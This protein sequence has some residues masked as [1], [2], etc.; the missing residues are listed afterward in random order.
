LTECVVVGNGP[1]S[2]L[3][4]GTVDYA[5]NV[6]GGRYKPQYLYAVDPWA[7]FDIVKS[8]YSG[9]CRFRDFNPLPIDISITA[10]ILYQGGDV[11]LDYDMLIH[12]PEHKDEADGWVYYCTGPTMNEHWDARVKDNSDYW[13]PKRVYILYVLRD[14]QIES[15]PQQEIAPAR[16]APTGAYALQG[17]INDGYTDITVYGFDSIADVYNTTSRE[18]WQTDPEVEKAGGA[19]FRYHY[20]KIMQN[21]PNV[22]ITWKGI[23]A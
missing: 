14:M 20:D 3:Y 5:C 9:K 1:S 4:T 15:V 10:E 23:D 12:N 6:S 16:I 22:N 13:M 11:P 21:N 18:N 19:H 8:A 17:A 2:E 7:Q